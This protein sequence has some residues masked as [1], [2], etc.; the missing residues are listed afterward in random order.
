MNSL[1]KSYINQTV[2]HFF[3]GGSLREK[4]NSFN[5]GLM[6][7]LVKQGELVLYPNNEVTCFKYRNEVYFNPAFPKLA[8]NKVVVNLRHLH[9]SLNKKMD[10]LIN[11]TDQLTVAEKRFEA[12]CNRAAKYV[13]QEDY[14]LIE[15]L[16]NDVTPYLIVVFILDSL[17]NN[18]SDTVWLRSDL[19]SNLHNTFSIPAKDFFDHSKNLQP[20]V[21]AFKEKEK[22]CVDQLDTF[23]FTINVLGF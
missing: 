21:N 5:N 18:F 6:D 3:Y 10:A 7:I 12:Y 17:P 11:L 1:V 19:L 4:R 8:Q 22:T 9:P 2:N 23:M 20:L 13:V 14:S 16:G 15:G